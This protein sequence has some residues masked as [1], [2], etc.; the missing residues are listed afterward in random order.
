MMR[1]PGRWSGFDVLGASKM[2][3]AFDPP[4]VAVPFGIFSN[5]AWQ[6]EGRTLHI[7][8][9]VA[10]DEDWNLIGGDDMAAQTRQVL[11]NIQKILESVGG[12]MD[13]IVSVIVYVTDMTPLMDVHKVRGEFFSKPYP[14]STLVQVP[15]LVKPEFL[16]E[17]S[18]VATIPFD[19]VKA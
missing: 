17:I 18:A 16:I 1:T 14:A 9:Q 13:D 6:P 11:L 4:G 12:T 7:A 2:A 15:A 3:D 8:G 10:V 5:A 19:R